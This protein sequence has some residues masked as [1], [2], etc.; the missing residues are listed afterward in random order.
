MIRILS[1][2]TRNHRRD[3]PLADTDLA[4][5]QETDAVDAGEW[6]YLDANG[7]LVRST[8]EATVEAKSNCYQVLTPK[9]STDMQVLEKC[10]VAFSRDYECETDMYDSNDTFSV[11]DPVGITAATVDGT[12]RMVF[13]N[14]GLTAD[15]DYIYGVVTKAPDADADNL[16]RV[17]VQS[18][19][20]TPVTY[21]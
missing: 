4:D 5:P 6:L 18:P 3:F 17:Q 11:G 14:S 15:T 1:H 10:A 9:G 2:L 8:V 16:L 19:Y 12:I 20:K 13:T 7:A 21:A